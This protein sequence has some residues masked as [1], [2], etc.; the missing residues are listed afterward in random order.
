MAKAE[1]T[2]ANKTKVM[3]EGMNPLVLEGVELAYPEKDLVW[4]S[5]G[6]CLTV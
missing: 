5:H 3:V 2:E 1:Q 4:S 6:P